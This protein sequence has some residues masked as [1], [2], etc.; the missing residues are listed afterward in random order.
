VPRGKIKHQLLQ[1]PGGIR[2]DLNFAAIPADRWLSSNNWLIRDGE[3]RPRPGYTLLATTADESRI[4][5][6]GYRGRP[7]DGTNVVVHTTDNAYSYNG[8]SL[9][10]I[11]GTW[12]VSSATQP[13]RFASYV[14]S[15]TTYI[16]RVNDAN[17]LHEWDGVGTDFVQTGGTPPA[18]ARDIC[19]AGGR[20]ILFRPGGNDYRVQWSGFN[21]RASW[22]VNDFTELRDTPGVV[23]AGRPLGPNS[24][25]VYKED[26]VYVASLQAALQPFQF[27]FVGRTS[28]PAS[29]SAL[30]EQNGI[31]YW[32]GED[33]N[34]YQF[35]GNRIQ[36][37]GEPLA[38][39]LKQ[40]FSISE[41]RRSFA[42]S[43]STQEPEIWFGYLKAGTSDTV[44]AIN[45]NLKT[46][47]LFSHTFS[48]EITAASEWLT[49][50]TSTIDAL[51]NYSAT[52]DG[53]S[54]VFA[55]IDAMSGEGIGIRSVLFGDSSGN[56]YAFGQ[57]QNDDGT[58]IAWHFEH[59]W[60]APAQVGTR[61]Y[62]DG[63]VS[64]WRKMTEALQVTVNLSVSDSLGDVETPQSKTFYLNEDSEHLLTFPNTRGQ[65]WKVKHSGQAARSTMRHRGAA[66]MGWPIGMV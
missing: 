57:A 25:A 12:A 34:L 38:D 15:G 2:E 3:G 31:H 42:F 53:L 18:S 10:A 16:L 56:L 49:Q 5:G 61:M 40:Q 4:I 47:A 55:S 60:Q 50:S 39:T 41:R 11:T 43:V 13:V 35:D 1:Y 20:V 36:P 8:T 30:I 14:Q 23:T 6:I 28:G 44:R 58:D 64:Y 17:S 37:Y 22:G 27:Q 7:L 54:S 29:A 62:C 45:Q 21:N 19:V 26:C 66:L 59:G 48:D 52:I 46:G 65:F 33:G 32:L 9:T 51:T 63:L 24:F